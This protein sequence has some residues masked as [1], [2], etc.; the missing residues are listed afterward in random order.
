MVSATAILC[1][2]RKLSGK[3]LGLL[4][5]R[6]NRHDTGMDMPSISVPGRPMRERH[7]GRPFAAVVS[8]CRHGLCIFRIGRLQISFQ[9]FRE[10]GFP[11]ISFTTGHFARYCAVSG[12][13]FQFC[14]RL[15][16]EEGI[17]FLNTQ[18][19]STLGSCGRVVRISD[20]QYM[21]MEMPCRMMR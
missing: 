2:L 9:I 6:V 1:D 18:T 12:D 3:I 10:L 8:M 21:K 14:F 4:L 7:T 15:M 19:V 5:S 17:Y 20:S 13:G 16:E 11:T